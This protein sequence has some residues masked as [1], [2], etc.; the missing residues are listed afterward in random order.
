MSRDVE[1]DVLYVTVGGLIAAIL[2]YAFGLSHRF[3]SSEEI[4][5]TTYY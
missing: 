4:G 2:G 3:F 5:S 1:R